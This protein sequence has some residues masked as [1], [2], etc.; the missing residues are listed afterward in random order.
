MTPAQAAKKRK[1]GYEWC[2][3]PICKH[4]LNVPLTVAE[5]QAAMRADFKKCKVSR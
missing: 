3:C 4:A 1:A 2:G 5:H